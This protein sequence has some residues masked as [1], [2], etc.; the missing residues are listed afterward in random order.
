M[1]P[2]SSLSPSPP[3]PAQVCVD[4]TDLLAYASEQST[5]SGIQRVVVRT[6]QGFIAMH[7]V[8]NVDIFRFN[9]AKN[10]FERACSDFFASDENYSHKSFCE[11]FA[12][13]S[14]R[15]DG[16]YASLG[17]YLRAKY[18]G[19]LLRQGY[20][21]LFLSTMNAIDGGRSFKKR[22]I[23][24]TAPGNAPRR[25]VNWRDARFRRDDRLLILGATWDFPS[26]GAALAQTKATSG[27][28]VCQMVHDLI[29]LVAPEYVSDE[30]ASRFEAYIRHV[31]QTADVIIANSFA[32]RKDIE[33][34]ARSWRIDRAAPIVV[35]LAQEF[36]LRPAD[37]AAGRAPPAFN[38]GSYRLRD[39]ATA[40]VLR[41]AVDPYVLVV[42]TIESRKN[43]TRLIGVWSRL[44][45]ER[46]AGT[47]KLILAGKPGFGSREIRAIL[48]ATG[49]LLG[50]VK[51]IDRPDDGELAFLYANCLFSVCVSYY[52]GWGLPVGESLWFGRPALASRSSSLPEA[53]GPLADYCDPYD[54][55]DIYE[56]LSR[57][58]FDPGHRAR[59]VEAINGAK[60]RTWDAVAADLWN[61]A[62]SPRTVQRGL[63]DETKESPKAHV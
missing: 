20:K 14:V 23:D 52:E 48:T 62:R 60:L 12:I 34:C 51:W 59:R 3:L 2:A 41:A 1:T 27:F 38:R 17:Q 53:G 46:P 10:G 26:Y 57:L 21:H 19:Q 8:E 45:Q 15:S 4:V 25:R 56:K 55:D 37:P 36:L 63:G 49:H 47:P 11:Y 28:T 6:I 40:R 42:G 44:R 9:P 35:P 50:K 16:S 31:F 54:D 43:L 39:H 18:K 32:T 33:T 7:G 13:D 61:A 5:V 24:L 58:I 22:K 30:A 29:P